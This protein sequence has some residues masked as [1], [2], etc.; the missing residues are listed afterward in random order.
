MCK[1]QYPEDFRILGNGNTSL[2]TTFDVNRVTS[3]SSE[4]EIPDLGLHVNLV[5][6]VAPNTYNPSG[7]TKHRDG[8]NVIIIYNNYTSMNSEWKL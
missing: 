8:A 6:T 5:Y 2:I 1:N 7:K 3:Q 4:I